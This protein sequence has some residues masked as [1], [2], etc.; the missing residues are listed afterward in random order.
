[1]NFPLSEGP[2]GDAGAADNALLRLLGWLKE[3]S[4]HFVTP[5]PATHERVL[6][7]PGRS[8]A[9]TVEDALGWS[10][11]FEAGLLPEDLHDS[12]QAAGMLKQEAGL[13]RS[14]VRVSTLHDCLYLHSAWPTLAE[15]AVFFGPDSYRFADLIVSEF[16]SQLP[17]DG[18]HIL[19]IGT[20]AGVGAIVAAM[21]CPE[22][23]IT[24]IDIN[25]LA[26]RIARINA[27]AA[28]ARIQVMEKSGLDAEEAGI[29][30]ALINPPYMIDPKRRTYR[31]GGEMHGGRV[32][33]DLTEVAI[34]RLAPGGRVVLYSGSAIVSGRD[35]LRIALS[36]LASASGCEMRYREV[37]PDVFGE[38]LETPAYADVDRIAV[39]A[40]ILSKTG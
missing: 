31:D 38:E 33:V 28:G 30:I 34:Q 7:R 14:V 10:L 18:A 36:R 15:D 16:T 25:P 5:T 12:L 4:Y 35:S 26:V 17:M 13:Y 32:A 29:D 21:I 37:D 6:A 40:A 9:R 24:A 2:D 19:D 3:R 27:E 22:A 8:R 20:G 1:M 11:P 39:I 23:R